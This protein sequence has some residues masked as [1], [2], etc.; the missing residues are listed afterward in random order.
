[1][2]IKRILPNGNIKKLK[3][4]GANLL[5]ALFFIKVLKVMEVSNDQQKKK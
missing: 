4:W 1:M 2:T 3:N 5:S